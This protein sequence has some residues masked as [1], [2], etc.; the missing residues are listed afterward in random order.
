MDVARLCSSLVR[1]KS[2]NP[3]G[4]TADVIEYIR[5]FL[6]TLGARSRVMSYPTAGRTSLRR[7]RI[8]GSFSAGTSMS[9]RR[10]PMRGCTT[11]TAARLPEGSSGGGAPRT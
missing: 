5:D 9:C 4:G 6:D 3:P 2:E 11:R 1:I 8:P 7:R 10:L